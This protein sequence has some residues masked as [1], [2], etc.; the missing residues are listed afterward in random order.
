MK[1][2]RKLGALA[3]GVLFGGVAGGL[4]V[5]YGPAFSKGTPWSGGQKI[6][7]LLLLPVAWMLAVL[8]HELGHVLLGRTKGFVFHW[9]AVGP[10][11]WK[12]ER[13]RLRFAWNKD[14][15]TAGGMALCVPPDSHDLRRRFL[16]FAG[17]GPLAS[18]LFTG[19]ALGVYALLPPATSGV[20]RVLGGTLA[21]SGAISA[22]LALVTLLPMHAGGF[23]SDGAR[24]LNLWRGGPAGQL[25]VA[26]LS[27]LVPSM[28][29][30]RPREL[31]RPLL[32]AA[33]LLPQEL[34]FKLYVFHYLYLIA[35]DT[36]H[37]ERAA[38]YLH[39]YRER[40]EWM[41]EALRGSG[42]LESAFFAAAYQHDLPAA[43]AFH[44]QAKPSPHTPADVP[45][46]V[47]AALARLA[48]DA[49][50]ARAKAQLALQE[51]PKSLDQGSA[52]LY[53][54][55]LMDTVRWAERQ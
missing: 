21:V 38:H 7:L 20:G 3:V 16:A 54:E 25:E 29:G 40:L 31:A 2:L 15:N 48:G 28:A 22:V 6:G 1:L 37:T 11:L 12:K 55:W 19:V 17:G 46:R 23:Y 41:P 5:K 18:G 36:G 45:A 24:V 14:L 53:A 4:G 52:R 50:L 39:A 34:P 33:A 9:L 13:G 51:L 30:T 42:W 27:A 10:F 8:A 44:A 43:R 32:E 26:V 47:E 35:L 49:D